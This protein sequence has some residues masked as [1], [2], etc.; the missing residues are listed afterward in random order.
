M[1][2]LCPLLPPIRNVQVA[3]MKWFARSFNPRHRVLKPSCSAGL[4]PAPLV[5]QALLPVRFTCATRPQT[6]S[7]MLGLR[8][9]LRPSEKRDENRGLAMPRG[10]P[11]DRFRPHEL[12][13][14]RSACA[15]C[16]GAGLLACSAIMLSALLP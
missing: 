4:R 2:I 14:G 9:K 3:V 16:L 12:R 6:I 1:P 5:A 15:T 10:V 8:V 11:T 13:T 7:A